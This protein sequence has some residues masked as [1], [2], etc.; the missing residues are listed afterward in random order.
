VVESLHERGLGRVR[1]ERLVDLRV[2]QA[3]GEPA[4]VVVGVRAEL[5]EPAHLL[6]GQADGDGAEVVLELG[7]LARADE[8]LKIPW[9][10]REEQVDVEIPPAPG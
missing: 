1:C 10:V 3:G 7:Q 5:V 9:V 4:R 6:G 8:S 2:A